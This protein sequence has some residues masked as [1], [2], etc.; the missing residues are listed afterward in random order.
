MGRS[1]ILSPHLDDAVL[2]CWHVLT[3]ADEAEVV[4]VFTGSPPAA[5]GIHPWWDRMTGASDP[6]ERMRERLAED[7]AALRLA[8][9][10]P[11]NLGFLDEQYRDDAQPLEPVIE[12]VADRLEPG[13]TLYAPA[14]LGFASFDHVLVRAAGLALAASGHPLR[15][16]ADLPHAV[17][18]GWPSWVTGRTGPVDPAYAWEHQ[19]AKTDVPLERLSATVHPLRADEEERKLEA[20]RLYAT[21]LPALDAMFGW[22]QRDDRFAYEVE[23]TV[24]EEGVGRP[25]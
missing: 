9:A 8:G 18:F 3:G 12:A 23:W 22:S 24:P 4:N 25:R 6:G 19:L 21:Q 7:R 15:L 5:N 16:Y 20:V 2:S 14:A 1:V 17:I 10:E 13:A 11:R